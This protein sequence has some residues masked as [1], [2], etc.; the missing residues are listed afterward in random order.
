MAYRTRAAQVTASCGLQSETRCSDGACV[1]ALGVPDLDRVSGW[2]RLAAS[3]PRFVFSTVARDL[4]V[5][6]RILPCGTAV[7]ALVGEG[8]VRTVELPSGDEV[9]CTVEGDPAEGDD[10]CDA[11]ATERAG[12]GAA[13]FHE[14]GLRELTFER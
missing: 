9:W 13:R 12:P 10:L 5:P 14:A 6:P 8:R 2:F 4:G 7:A 11:L 3:S 1:A